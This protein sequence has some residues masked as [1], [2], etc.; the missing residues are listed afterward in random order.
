MR[1]AYVCYWFLL[2]KDGVANKIN[3]QVAQW[4]DSGHEAEVFC[5]ARIYP[6]RGEQRTEWR[7]FFFDSTVGRLRATR[8]L[9]DGVRAWHPDRVY[10]RYDL[11]PP[12]LPSL[13]RRVPT[14]IEINADDRE[15]AKL[16]R[17]RA[18]AASAYNEL[19]RRAL[20]SRARG[21]VCVTNELARSPSFASFRK[22]T[23]VIANGVDLD[24]VR[25]L[26]APARADGRRRIAFLGS[27][28]Q[29]WHG[30]DKIAWLAGELPE[31]DFDVVG[32]DAALLRESLGPSIPANLHAHG[33]LARSDYEPI[34]A[35]ADLAIG[36]LALHRKK[37]H[38]ACPLKVREYLGY[39]LPVV[40][41]YDDTDLAGVDDWFLLRLPNEESNVR[42][43][44]ETI[45]AFLASVQGRRVP[46]DAVAERIGAKAKERRRL[47]FLERLDG[48]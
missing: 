10:L 17:T 7:T 26:A 21:L 27:A 8:E 16:R 37:M 1:V 20:L 33:V 46:R 5:L 38:E 14:A 13:L 4:R 48:A 18:R 35:A 24:A 30:V 44:V 2:E 32:Y 19:N 31:V 25:P 40:I 15:E 42:D 11:F 23:E 3:A 22:P 41:A 6:R 34:L 47:A 45:A 36:T 12:P 39:G 9:V 28:R 29:T 43:N